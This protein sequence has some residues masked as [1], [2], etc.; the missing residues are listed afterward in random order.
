[1]KKEN[2]AFKYY[3]ST[4]ILISNFIFYNSLIKTHSSLNNLAP[5]QVYGINY[6]YQEKASWFENVDFIYSL[7]IL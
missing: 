7:K 5:N 6:A 4:N 3:D 2:K 1:M